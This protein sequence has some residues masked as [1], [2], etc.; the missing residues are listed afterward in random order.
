MNFHSL[1][2]F[3]TVAEEK[4]ITHAAEKLF[5]SQQAL[6]KSI[7]KLEQELGVTL[8]QRTP[9]IQLTYAGQQLQQYASDIIHME[10]QMRIIA[11]DIQDSQRGSLRLGISHT[12]GRA[13]L[14]FLL[15]QF[16]ES[17]PLVELSLLEGNTME[18]QYALNQGELDLVI[19]FSPIAPEDIIEIPLMNE[20]LFLV[21]PPSI[22]EKHFGD[23][24]SLIQKQ[25]EENL[26]LSIFSNVPFIAL[27]KGNRLRTMIDQYGEK[28]HFQ[29]NILLETENTETA[30][31]LAQ[32][33]IGI[34][35]YPELFRLSIPHRLDK[36]GMVYFFPIN[37][38]TT[39]GR[40]VIAWN[41]QQ[42][43]TQTAKDFIKLC[44]S[45]FAVQK[46]D[47]MKYE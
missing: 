37:D 23:Q 25:S 44:R 45:A 42:Y 16:H 43:Q 4:N 27:K 35:I 19:G 13:V 39:T 10:Q 46:P 18:L 14:P 7:I 21:V 24:A 40:L 28:T 32:S 33:G 9:G 29:P 34:T 3:L 15:P 6:S 22:L 17:H 31:A 5:I 8:F 47:W 20:R 26:D 12:C 1:Q 11:K 30:F 41:R 38:E 2:N 36:D